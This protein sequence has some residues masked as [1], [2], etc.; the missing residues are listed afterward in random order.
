MPCEFLGQ[1][2]VSILTR[3]PGLDRF[4][5]SGQLVDDLCRQDLPGHLEE[6]VVLLGDVSPEKSGIIG[7]CPG[8][9]GGIPRRDRLA[10]SSNVPSSF[11]VI[12]KHAP[13]RSSPDGDP[14]GC[15]GWKEELLL[16]FVMV[17]VGKVR[18]EV[19]RLLVE[20]Q[21]LMFR[22]PFEGAEDLFDEA[23][24]SLEFID[25]VHL[26]TSHECLGGRSR[27]HETIGQQHVEDAVPFGG[28]HLRPVQSAP[29]RLRLSFSSV[30]SE[31][32][33]IPPRPL[34]QALGCDIGVP[35]DAQCRR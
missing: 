19:N 11:L 35:P 33:A 17:L 24:V 20:S 26:K 31:W 30:H 16:F 3:R 9:G 2:S 21:G 6:D 34:R 25:G 28:H 8:R 1:L 32:D 14:M 13:D 4:E 27:R 7:T 10:H 23:M 12:V 29:P 15:Q 5:L 22:R 18:H